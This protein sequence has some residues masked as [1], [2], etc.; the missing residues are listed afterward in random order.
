MGRTKTDQ[1]WRFTCT[2]T[3]NLVLP[4]ARAQAHVRNANITV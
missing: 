2:F 4:K 1:N 3:R